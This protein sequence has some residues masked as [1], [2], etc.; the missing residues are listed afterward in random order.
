MILDQE[1]RQCI[2]YLFTVKDIDVVIF[3]FYSSALVRHDHL[4]R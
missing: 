1:Y 2:L 4:G 3:H